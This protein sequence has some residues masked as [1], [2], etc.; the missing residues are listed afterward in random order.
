MYVCV[1]VCVY[2]FGFLWLKMKFFTLWHYL[3]DKQTQKMMN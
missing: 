3:C 2:E 1:C